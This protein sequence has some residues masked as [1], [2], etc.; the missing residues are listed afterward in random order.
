MTGE[1]M[2]G[3]AG[4]TGEATTGRTEGATGDGPGRRN[5]ALRKVLVTWGPML[6]HPR[7]IVIL[8]AK[9]R[10]VLLIPL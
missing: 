5:I 10:F 2:T 9:S 4:M 8:T 7:T 3:T 6:C 1:A